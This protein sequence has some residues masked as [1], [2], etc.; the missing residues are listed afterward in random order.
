MFT[1]GF[2]SCGMKW[3]LFCNVVTNFAFIFNTSCIGING[4]ETYRAGWAKRR[5]IGY[6]SVR[7][8]NNFWKLNGW[9]KYYIIHIGLLYGWKNEVDY[10]VYD[11]CRFFQFI[12]FFSILFLFFQL[13]LYLTCFDI[14]F[15]QLIKLHDLS[16]AHNGIAFGG[17][18]YRTACMKY[19][20][21]TWTL[22][23]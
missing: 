22:G 9:Y 4:F 6:H 21:S 23:A 1:I 7:F 16:M 20:F 14:F 17:T 5:P 8:S 10:T 18:A 3:M 11:M 2:T 15:S 12:Y 19:Q 13:H